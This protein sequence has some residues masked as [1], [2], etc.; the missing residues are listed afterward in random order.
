MRVN[1]YNDFSTNLT[2]LGSD[3]GRV[4]VVAEVVVEVKMSSSRSKSAILVD[5]D[6]FS[7]AADVLDGDLDLPAR[8]AVLGVD[9]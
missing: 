5:L 1:W 8:F 7:P 3:L 9:F 6:P 2:C 4:V